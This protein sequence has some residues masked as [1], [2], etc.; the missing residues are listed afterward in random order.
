MVL[1]VRVKTA[2]LS[3]VLD[4]VLVE[5]GL[6]LERSARLEDVLQRVVRAVL[7]TRPVKLLA[8]RLSALERGKEL[9]R[10]VIRALEHA[11]CKPEVAIKSL[12]DNAPRRINM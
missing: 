7:T 1:A 2:L 9:D 12:M 10:R 5:R 11:A 8:R 3:L 6:E 4:S